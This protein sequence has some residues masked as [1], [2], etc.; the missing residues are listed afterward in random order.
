MNQGHPV[1]SRERLDNKTNQRING[2]QTTIQEFGWRMERRFLVKSK[3]DKRIPKK[4]CDGE[5]NV[6]R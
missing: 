1:G 3:K 5:E 4:C 6:D 2:C